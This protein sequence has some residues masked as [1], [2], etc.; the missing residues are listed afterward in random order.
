[1]NYWLG[2]ALLL[3][4]VCGG[5]IWLLVFLRQRGKSRPIVENLI[6]MIL[7]LFL[8]FM[9]IEFYFKVF[10]VQMDALHS[11]A[12]QNWY[13][14]YYPE[15][16]MNSL[17]YRDVEWT[18]EMVAGKTKVMVVG[19]SFAEGVGIESPE[20]RFSNLL[21]QKLGSNYVVF[22][23][24]KR[25][26]NTQQEIK[27]IIDYPYSPD[28]LILSYF[29]NDI[30]DIRWWHNENRPPGPSV[31]P[32]LSPLV[33]N[34]YALN[35]I[36]WRLY[37]VLQGDHLEVWWYWLQSLYDDPD[38]WWLHQQNL[39][40]IYEGTRAEQI[41]FLVV[42]FPNLG[43]IEGSAAITGQIIDLYAERGVPVL[44]VRELVKDISPDALLVSPVDSH[45]SELVHQLV[46]EAL[47][48]K[49]VALKLY[50]AANGG[51]GAK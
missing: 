14:R 49:F 44:D 33:D 45:P 31:L 30:E 13:E 11:L 38:V 23:L 26:A 39:L 48:E 19:D 25:G 40:S 4:V 9:A 28:I 36:Y 42:V 35:F 47:Y 8:T 37:R 50:D 32:Y 20:G 21:A 27:A 46:A 43:D 15:G 12:R 16:A 1:M 34:S 51:A 5:L 10:F 7:T 6:I 2:Y 18:D 41:P 3:F 17:G 29:I 24:G 22:N